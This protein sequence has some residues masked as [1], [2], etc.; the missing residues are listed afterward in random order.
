MKASEAERIGPLF[1]T[2]KQANL[3]KDIDLFM[4]CYS[5][6]FK[7]RKSKRFDILETWKNIPYLDLAYDL[8]EQTVYGDT[9]SVR[10]EWLMKISQKGGQN[11]EVNRILL[12]V[13]LKREEA[14]WKIQEIKPIS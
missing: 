5:L 13:T 12:E 2:I 14:L 8:K 9:A 11:P 1:E 10:V 3:K 6:D 4:S 7:D